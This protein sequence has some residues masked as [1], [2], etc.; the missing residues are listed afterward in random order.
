MRLIAGTEKVLILPTK[1]DQTK[2]RNTGFGGDEDRRHAADLFPDIFLGPSLFAFDV[3]KLF[4]QVGAGHWG[5]LCYLR[6]CRDA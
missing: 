1:H 2:L 5:F 3:E 6:A 4:S